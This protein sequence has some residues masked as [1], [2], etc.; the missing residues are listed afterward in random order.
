MHMTPKPLARPVT[1]LPL[2]LGADVA[3]QHKS[4]TPDKLRNDDATWKDKDMPE[5]EHTAKPEDY[6]RPAKP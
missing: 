3:D 6:E 5:A 2:N 4:H 1:K